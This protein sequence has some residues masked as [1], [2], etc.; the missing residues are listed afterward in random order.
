MAGCKCNAL[1]G[2]PFDHVSGLLE[3]GY[4]GMGVLW[5]LV[6][7]SPPA[8]VVLPTGTLVGDD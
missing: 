3:A 8:F 5:C 2:V 7:G 6:V 4:H 1:R